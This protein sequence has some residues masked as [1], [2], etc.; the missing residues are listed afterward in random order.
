MS[1]GMFSSS[2]SQMPAT[3]GSV[4]LERRLSHCPCI[5]VTIAGGHT[6]G[7]EDNSHEE[8]TLQLDVLAAQPGNGGGH[9]VHAA[10]S[11][12]QQAGG[13]LSMKNAAM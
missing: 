8:E 9:E 2:F 10:H 6:E 12:E 11:T 1:A 4:E 5:Y 7:T 13:Y 3:H